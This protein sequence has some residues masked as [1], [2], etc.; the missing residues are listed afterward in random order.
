M[1]PEGPAPGT[2]PRDDRPAAPVTDAPL[3]RLLQ[4]A[5]ACARRELAT[6][7][8]EGGPSP[9]QTVLDEIGVPSEPAVWHPDDFCRDH[10]V[11]LFVQTVRAGTPDECAAYLVR[12]RRDLRVYLTGG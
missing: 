4:D 3:I 5:E 9:L 1:E 8:G 2:F 6:G 12:A 10:W 11:E 7:R